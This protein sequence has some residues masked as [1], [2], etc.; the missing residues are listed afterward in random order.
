MTHLAGSPLSSDNGREIQTLDDPETFQ[1][2][3]KPSASPL[4][5]PKR[6]GQHITH[7]GTSATDSSTGCGGLQV[8]RWA[9]RNR[10]QV[11]AGEE[12]DGLLCR[13]YGPWSKW[14][15][16]NR[17]CQQSRVRK[18]RVSEQCGTT[19]LKERRMCRRRRG[20]CPSAAAAV[21]RRQT[22]SRLHQSNKRVMERVL[23]D[24]VYTDWSP[25]GSCTRSCKQRR[26]RR[27]KVRSVCDNNS[28]QETRRCGV[29]GS[30]CERR[31]KQKGSKGHKGHQTEA[32]D[33]PTMITQKPAGPVPTKG[34]TT[35]PRTKDKQENSKY[36]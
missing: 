27:C 14:R 12:V 31:H 25:W 20:R 22:M 23:Y 10:T 29:P 17:R 11:H 21:F 1:S 35:R 9:S 8:Q 16:C 19:R 15:R 6:R 24:S 18:C 2:R 26:R 13:Y 33:T 7:T 3:S 28:V 30:R 34:M 4:S 32:T 5:S 36:Q